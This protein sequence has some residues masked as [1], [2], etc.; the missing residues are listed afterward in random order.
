M[1]KD[2]NIKMTV[3]NGRLMA[4]IREKYDSVS[5]FCRAA[6]LGVTQ[7]SA[8]MTFRE[9]PVLKSGDWKPLAADVAAALGVYPSDIW[10]EHL[11][12]VRTKRATAELEI[13]AAEVEAIGGVESQVLQRDLLAKWSKSL[14]PR[15]TLAIG[16]FLDDM[17]LDEKGEALG[18]GRE[19]ARQ[20]E[21]KA[22]RKL[23][24]AAALDNVKRFH[25]AM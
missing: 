3:R 13:S 9:T 17:T 6:E 23:R 19:R 14:T 8:L 21:C 15:E 24:E 1:S 18:V 11:Q 22:L 20:I 5:A 16:F 10:P 7:V 4:L 25:D 12:E 2:F